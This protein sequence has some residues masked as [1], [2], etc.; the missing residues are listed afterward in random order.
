MDDG[1]ASVSVTD[2]WPTTQR[3]T[4]LCVVYKVCTRS[5]CSWDRKPPTAAMKR[6]E[7]IK[8]CSK[9][10]LPRPAPIVDVC[11]GRVVTH[12]HSQ[13]LSVSL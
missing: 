13:C 9:V 5:V 8:V 2:G 10:I 11:C 4:I 7:E 12:R 1:V 6:F 3:A